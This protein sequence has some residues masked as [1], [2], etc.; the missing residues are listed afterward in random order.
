MCD[1]LIRLNMTIHV[2]AFQPIVNVLNWKHIHIVACH[3]S[4][5]PIK[6]YLDEHAGN[7]LLNL[8]KHIEYTGCK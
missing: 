8:S 5:I 2:T 1:S 7:M 3:G 6:N 4:G